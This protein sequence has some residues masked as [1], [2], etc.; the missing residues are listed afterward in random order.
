MMEGS[1][2]LIGQIPANQ[3]RAR[4]ISHVW[5][6][7]ISSRG[8]DGVYASDQITGP[9]LSGLLQQGDTGQKSNLARSFMTQFMN[10]FGYPPRVTQYNNVPHLV[11]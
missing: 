5:S 9:L 10:Q 7:S 11:Q 3:S 6:L 8:P 2:L 4:A 1:P